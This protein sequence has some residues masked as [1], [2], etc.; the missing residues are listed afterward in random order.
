MSEKPIVARVFLSFTVS[1]SLSLEYLGFAKMQMLDLFFL[2]MSS[3]FTD[4]V[5]RSHRVVLTQSELFQILISDVTH[6]QKYAK[7]QFL[8]LF[9]L[10][11]TIHLF[12]TWKKSYS[13]VQTNKQEL[14]KQHCPSHFLRL[15]KKIH[16]LSHQGKMPKKYD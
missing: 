14:N 15:L 16:C 13:C 9:I 12:F 4:L 7:L 5:K 11:P 3:N 10:T 6:T 1:V 8:S 2:Y